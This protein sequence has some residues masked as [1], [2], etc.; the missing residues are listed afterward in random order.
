MSRRPKFKPEI[1]RIKLNPEQAVAVCS[2]YDS[3]QQ[4]MVSAYSFSVAKKL[5]CVANQKSH[6]YDVR[7]DG[8]KGTPTGDGR[9][10]TFLS[11]SS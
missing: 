4:V 6:V 11:A 7:C 5:G 1:T 8:R 3:G 2:C 9:G 10:A